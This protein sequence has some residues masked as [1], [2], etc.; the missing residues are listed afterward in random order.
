MPCADRNQ[1][2]AARLYE[3]KATPPSLLRPI[4][5]N[6]RVGPGGKPGLRSAGAISLTGNFHVNP[7]AIANNSSSN[8][9][10]IGNFSSTG[11]STISNFS[12]TGNRSIGSSTIGNS[13]TGSSTIGN[14]STGSFEFEGDKCYF[15]FGVKPKIVFPVMPPGATH[16]FALTAVGQWLENYRGTVRQVCLALHSRLTDD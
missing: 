3:A 15:P 2:R 10:T 13:S 11:S 6:S 14:S 5:Q 12:S 9:S 16:P 7:F 1:R 8:S 4:D